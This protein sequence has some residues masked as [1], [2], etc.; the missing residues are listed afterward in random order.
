MVITSLPA[1]LS[2]SIFMSWKWVISDG[3]MI[4]L[5]NTDDRKYAQSLTLSLNIFLLLK[6]A[7]LAG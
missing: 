7:D 1:R 5:S 3:I 6:K 2:S 4:G